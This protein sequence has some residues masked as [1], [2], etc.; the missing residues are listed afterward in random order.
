MLAEGK[1]QSQAARAA[2]IPPFRARE[3]MQ[4]VQ[5]WEESYLRQAWTVFM[6]ADSALKG[7][8]A[9]Q[10]KLILDDLVIQLCSVKSQ[11][12]AR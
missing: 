5:G 9:T 11:Q 1:D 6:D 3:L 12:V 7:G 2:G 4:Q 8:R 10:P